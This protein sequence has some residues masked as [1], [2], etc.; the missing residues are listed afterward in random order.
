MIDAMHNFK[1]RK[2]IRELKQYR[3]RHTELISVYIPAG[4]DMNK[5]TQHL[6]DEQGTASNIKDK[7][8]RKN[9]QDALE[10]MI[11]HLKI[12]NQTPAHG[13]AVFSG[14]ISSHEGKQDIKV[15]SIEPP[16][17]VGIRLYRCDQTF[18]LDH[19]ENMVVSDEVYGLIVLDNREATIGLL[20]GKT[21]Q[22]IR[23]FTSAVPGKVKVGGWCLAADTSVLM[24][25]NT[26]NLRHL[27]V[28][29]ELKAYDFKNQKQVISKCTKIWRSKKNALSIL[30]GGFGFIYKDQ[31]FSSE[32]HLF[33]IYDK[34]NKIK[35]IPASKLKIGD[36]LLDY[37]MKK[38]KI[39]QIFKPNQET[40]KIEMIDIETEHGNFFANGI[41]VHN[42]QQRYARL[43]EEAANEFY[44]RIADVA[45][46]EF[47]NIGKTLKGILIGGPGP[48][49]NIFADKDHL[50][51][52]LK[53][54]IIAAEDMTYTD[55]HG[56][57]ELVEK[58]QDKIAESE[59]SKEKKILNEFF[60]MLST[61]SNKALYGRDDVL[62][63]MEYGAVDKLLLSESFDELEIFEEKAHAIGA[64]VFIIS[65][66]TMEGG[67]LRD[68]GG[69]AA[70]LRY[71][72]EI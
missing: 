29:D 54:K 52:E 65:V 43:R 72:V 71:A 62:K 38:V 12:Y 7:T 47:E 26:N 50:H 64:Q 68:L 30:F 18:V 41:L 16:V 27:K 67:Q 44:K 49:K 39:K 15:W 66:E 19:L 70:I 60:V 20:K 69:I 24:K 21:I 61:S 34:N 45:N 14:N 13:L 35:K 57:H 31:I 40:Q 1:L 11:R 36:L 4:Y 53:K 23:K 6:F 58:A 51:A 17:P 8:T 37:N 63:A 25:D 32:D 59:M 3:A 5:I 56:L 42:S 10:K 22:V 28:G 2:F 55:E 48:T 9:V 33:F 46:V